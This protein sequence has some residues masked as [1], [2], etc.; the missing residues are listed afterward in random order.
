[1]SLYIPKMSDTPAITIPG[2]AANFE[3][4]DVLVRDGATWRRVDT[5]TAPVEIT[6]NNYAAPTIVPL[7]KPY[8][9]TSIYA[10]NFWLGSADDRSN[11]ITFFKGTADASAGR[12]IAGRPGG[13]NICVVSRI[14]VPGQ[15]NAIGFF[16]AI[17]LEEVP[18]LLHVA[19][20]FAVKEGV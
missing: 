6:S 1:M 7:S 2:L 8:S 16:G 14:R 5:L 13:R 20:V 18:V 11:N 4:L 10:V 15:G 12:M 9:S 3:E 17:D 19:S